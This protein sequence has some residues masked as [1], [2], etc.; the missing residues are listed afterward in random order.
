MT[1]VKVEAKENEFDHCGP[2]D[3]KNKKF[4]PHFRME[5]KFFPEAK[6]WKVGEEYTVKLKLK[7][8]GISISKFQN[9]SEFD[10][11]GVDMNAKESK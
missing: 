10:I 11:V 1:L 8:T 3:G 5:H 2:S 7:M 4:L 9:E 6:K